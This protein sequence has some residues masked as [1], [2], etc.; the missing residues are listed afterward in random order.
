SRPRT[1]RGL[2]MSARRAHCG[3]VRSRMADPAKPMPIGVLL[4]NLGTPDSPSVADVRRYLAEFL[5]DPQVID[6]PAPL[7]RLLLHGVIL[8]TR[9]ARSAAAY[10]SIWTERGSPLRF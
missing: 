9:P 2:E 1:G 8:R 7:R 3:R 5:A 4:L 6:L 10:R